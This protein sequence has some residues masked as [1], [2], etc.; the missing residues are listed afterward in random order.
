LK[1]QKGFVTVDTI[2]NFTGNKEKAVKELVRNNISDLIEFGLHYS[3][4]NMSVLNGENL[5]YSELRFTEASVTYLITLMRNSDTVKLFKKN[6]VSDFYKLKQFTEEQTKKLHTLQLNAKDQVIA[7]LSKKDKEFKTIVEKG[8]TYRSA[9]AQAKEHNFKAKEL[10]EF[11]RDALNQIKVTYKL[12]PEWL[13]KESAD[14]QL[15]VPDER[16]VPYY[17]D[18]AID[19]FLQYQEEEE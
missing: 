17:S 14:S 2:V 9:Q 8:S 4:K 11:F 16:G 12:K 10:K 1:E 6:L 3:D 18:K 19:L 5:N 13:V 7:E 15:I